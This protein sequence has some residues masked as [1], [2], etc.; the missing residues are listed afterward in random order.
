[1][2][3]KISVGNV[4][5]EV[6]L[7]VNKLFVKTLK[8]FV[9][10]DEVADCGG[11]SC[12]DGILIFNNG[13]CKSAGRDN[14]LGVPDH[15]FNVLILNYGKVAEELIV[16]KIFCSFF[17]VDRRFRKNVILVICLKSNGEYGN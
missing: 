3:S 9:A 14:V 4:G 12:C 16:L 11:D 10:L 1:M 7:A 13:A 5:N 2:V 6:L 17:C 8:G 15:C